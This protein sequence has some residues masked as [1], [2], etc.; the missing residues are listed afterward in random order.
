MSV[1]EMVTSPSNIWFPGNIYHGYLHHEDTCLDESEGQHSIVVT[2]REP[3]WVP[4]GYTNEPPHMPLEALFEI[5][6]ICGLGLLVCY[7]GTKMI[8]RTRKKRDTRRDRH[9][10]R[11]DTRGRLRP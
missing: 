11:D 4:E 3:I 9:G 7:I 6:G 5:W 1:T 8:D 2:N 10:H